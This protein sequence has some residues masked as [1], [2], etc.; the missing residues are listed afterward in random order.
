LNL[1]FRIKSK[2]FCFFRTINSILFLLLFML[3]QK[4]FKSIHQFLESEEEV[5]AAINRITANTAFLKL[6]NY[7]FP[8]MPAEKI[9]DD[10]KNISSVAEFQ[11]KF[12]YPMIRAILEKTSSGLTFSGFE[13]IKPDQAYLFISN[14]RDIFL[15]SAIL[16]ILLLEQGLPTTEISSG[17]NLMVSPVLADMV[18]LNKMVTVYRDEG[19]SRQWYNQEKLLSEFIRH[20]IHDRKI[21]VWIAQRNGRTK[22][23]ADKTQPGLLKMLV[24]G[25]NHQLKSNFKQLNIVPVSMSYEYEP[26]DKLKVAELNASGNGYKKTT[27]EDLHSIISGITQQKGHIHLAV[28][29]PINDDLDKIDDSLNDNQQ[30][31]A[32]ANLIDKQ[33]HNNY[34]L[35]PTNYIAADLLAGAHR[36]ADFYS[37]ADKVK[38]EGHL[39][40]QCNTLNGDTGKFWQMF[41]EMYANPLEN[42]SQP[43]V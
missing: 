39:V 4:D 12:M 7:L 25:L 18:R 3:Y 24:M 40:K 17:S 6:S 29:Q 21:S 23:G 19:T 33:I 8:N 31:Q 43:T 15:D 35:W 5:K 10:L 30:I 28:C 41:L 9:T 14:H 32:I 34:K 27:H 36:Y 42:I 11:K 16:N 2:N 38:F 20:S 22:D 26:C 37:V 1:V 13:N